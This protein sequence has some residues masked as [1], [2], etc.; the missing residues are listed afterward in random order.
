MSEIMVFLSVLEA[1]AQHKDVAHRVGAGLRSIKRWWAA[2]KRGQSMETKAKSGHPKILN[3]AD[4]IVIS[5]YLD[6]RRHSTLIITKNLAEKGYAASSSTVYRHFSQ[7]LGAR[8]F[9]R[10]QKPR[11]TD[12]IKEN[13]LSFARNHKNWTVED[14]RKVFWSDESP[15]ELFSTTNRQNDRV[16]SKNGKD[17]SPVLKVKFP[18]KVM[19]W[20][21]TS[22]RALSELHIIPQKQSVNATIYWVSLVLMPLIVLAQ[23]E[24]YWRDR[25]CQT[26]P[27]FYSCRM[28]LQHIRRKL[29]RSGVET[30]F[31]AIGRKV[32]GQRILLT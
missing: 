13:R 28:E 30:I 4:K 12:R 20:G 26:C 6:K 22:H 1:G 23:Q 16:W 7:N 3:R 11:I 19:V 27:I 8:A 14:W 10:P 29:L 24:V 18:A 2:A 32:S 9:K 17:I 21:M 31:P 15:F 5:K 25:C